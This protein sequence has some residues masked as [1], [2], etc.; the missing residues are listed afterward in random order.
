VFG[1]PFDGVANL[2]VVGGE[3]P[4][5]PLEQAP[6]S[7]HASPTHTQSFEAST[8]AFR[9]ATGMDEQCPSSGAP[10]REAHFSRARRPRDRIVRATARLRLADAGNSASY[11]PSN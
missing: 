4:P 7:A 11:T 9:R 2:V 10:K 6:A 8:T 1:V 3:G 5:P